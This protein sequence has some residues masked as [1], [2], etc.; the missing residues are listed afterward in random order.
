MEQHHQAPDYALILGPGVQD[1]YGDRATV[2][3]RLRQPRM[4]ANSRVMKPG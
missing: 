1:E 2:G 4:T 3:C